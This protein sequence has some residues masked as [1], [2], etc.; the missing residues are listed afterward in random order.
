M[1][2]WKGDVRVSITAEVPK[3]RKNPFCYFVLF[4]IMFRNMHHF[5]TIAKVFP[6]SYQTAALSWTLPILIM[7]ALHG[8]LQHIQRRQWC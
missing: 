6:A 5:S 8:D 3:E 4:W 7:L 2:D 1:N